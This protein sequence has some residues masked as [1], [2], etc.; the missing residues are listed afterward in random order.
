MR[1]ELI[2]IENIER[3][4]LNQMNESEKIDF[5]KNIKSNPQLKAK[6]DAQKLVMDAVERIALKQSTKN[7]YKSYKIKALLTKLIIV[8]TIITAI[9]FVTLKYLNS[10]EN[11][12]FLPK[13]FKK[14]N[15]L[16][17][18]DSIST[19]SNN[20]LDK[21][22]FHINS[23]K[24]TVIENK[25]GLIIYIPDNAFDTESE[26]IELLVQSALK[27]EDILYAGLST[28]SNG[29]ELETGG[30][31]YIDAFNQGKRVNLIKNIDV[32]VPTNQKVEGMQLYKGKK[33]NDGEINWVNPQPLQNKLTPVDI[34]TLDFFPP[35]Y[36]N[37]LTN[38]GYPNKDFKDSLYYSFAFED[39]IM[40][41][42][43]GYL[44]DS[45]EQY[46]P[47]F[48]T[49]SE[50]P[51]S[52]DEVIKW[53][54]KPI[55]LGNS[56]YDLTFTVNQFDGWHIFSQKLPE[57][58]VVIPTTFR[59][60]GKGFK[61]IGKTREFYSSLNLNK[62]FPEKAFYGKK[63]FFKQKV[64]I[65]EKIANISI[66]Y[67]YM[68]CKESCFP[69]EFNR[70]IKI[71]ISK[72]KNK[73]INPASIKTI[74]NTKFN[75]TNLATK[76]FEERLVWIHKSCN[77]QVLDLYVNNLDKSLAEIDSL[78]IPLVKGEVKTKFIEFAKRN[79]G[80]VNISDKAGQKLSKYFSNKRKAEAKA[81]VETQQNYWKEQNTKDNKQIAAENESYKRA[82]KNRA[83][84][85]QKEFKKNLCKVYD[86]LNYPIDCNRPPL[87]PSYYSV[88]VSQVGWNNIDKQ[89]YVATSKRETTSFTYKG[90]TS[91][92]TYNKWEG[93]VKNHQKFERIN[94]YNIPKEFKSYVK[95]AGNKGVY[96]YKLNADLN[97]QTVVL[98]WTEKGLFYIIKDTKAGKDT[99]TLI[100]VSEQD[101]KTKVKSI[102]SDVHNMSAEIDFVTNAQKD[103][104]RQKEN[105]KRKE[106]RSKIKPVVFPCDCNMDSSYVEEVIII[107]DSL[108][109]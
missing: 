36:N 75:N 5:E 3:Y 31:F 94:V 108:D 15:L 91:S 25:D 48:D 93:F 56:Y 61:L 83:K 109:M 86:E 8:L 73:N 98:A 35:N 41:T 51:G 45:S 32:N 28:T 54:L 106:L 23:K 74:W 55:N 107:K 79:D 101:F 52:V 59:Y 96:N 12:E 39:V 17:K 62:E 100:E 21:E 6:V 4:L 92:V 50:N 20:F 71:K 67:S 53:N 10:K 88:K 68:A 24:D 18:N 102:L 16:P 34:L 26:N 2:E 81:L 84:V 40:T 78:V 82:Y 72:I 29:N 95:I 46:K 90:K 49:I 58:S 76:E 9:S 44:Q 1:K 85:F 38:W 69:P 66:W 63:A 27:A 65:S 30:M 80:K 77:Q 99:F 33:T 60:E 103:I 14:L 87:A 57:G 105:T 7:S 47:V 104:K 70:S 64:F 37:T 89:V 13:T 42:T 11:V 22:V 97:Y 43:T 19:F